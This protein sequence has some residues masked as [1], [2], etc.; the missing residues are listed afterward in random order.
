MLKF[1]IVCLADSN[2]HP[3]LSCV[4]GPSQP[5]HFKCISRQEYTYR[6]AKA[7]LTF[8]PALLWLQLA[9]GA[10]GGADGAPSPAPKQRPVEGD[11]PVYVPLSCV[12]A[13]F[14]LRLA[15]VS[16]HLPCS[17]CAWLGVVMDSWL[18]WL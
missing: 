6:T 13:L 12:P 15:L 9:G 16:T 17:H 1:I 7:R 11:C 14:S 18:R 8:V 2:R 5:G 10:A 3:V 4:D